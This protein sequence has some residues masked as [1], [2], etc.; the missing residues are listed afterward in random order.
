MIDDISPE[1]YGRANVF[2][3][4]TEKSLPHKAHNAQE[5]K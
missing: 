5:K 3:T 2:T 4:K 1:G